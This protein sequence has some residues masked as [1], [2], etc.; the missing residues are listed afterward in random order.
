MKAAMDPRTGQHLNVVSDASPGDYIQFYAELDLLVV[1]SLCPYGDGAV[2][3]SDWATTPISRRPI[4]IEVAD[5][6]ALPLGWP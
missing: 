4:A 1:V 6:G 5:S 3:P 2:V